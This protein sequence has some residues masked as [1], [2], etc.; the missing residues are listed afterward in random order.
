MMMDNEITVERCGISEE[1]LDRILENEY[2]QVEDKEGYNPA[3]LDSIQ[4]LESEMDS[5][6][7]ENPHQEEPVT[8]L[9]FP[10]NPGKHISKENGARRR[11][12][13]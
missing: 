12:I 9:S 2:I 13:S 1:E 6:F 8:I 10:N 11:K 3:F 7:F 5:V 4:A